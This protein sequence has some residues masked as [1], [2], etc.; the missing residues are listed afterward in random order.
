MYILFPENVPILKNIAKSNS[1]FAGV[2]LKQIKYKRLKSLFSLPTEFSFFILIIIPFFIYFVYMKKP[3]KFFTTLTSVFIFLSLVLSKSFGIIVGL[4]FLLLSLFLFY[5][6]DKKT[7]EKIT[8]SLFFIIFSIGTLISYFRG[9]ELLDLTPLRLRMF[10]WIIAIKEFLLSPFYGVGLGNFGPYSSF[11]IKAGDPQSKY[12]HN[13]FLQLF[14]ETGVI[15]TMIFLVFLIYII[16][17]IINIEKNPFNIAVISSLMVFLSYNLIDIGVS[18]LSFGFLF[19]IL[20]G[21]LLKNSEK[22]IRVGSRG[23]AIIILL[24]ILLIPV[25]YSSY[26][27]N[28]AKYVWIVDN[29]ESVSLSKQASKIFPFNPISK[30]IECSYYIE[31][32]QNNKS[33]K[34]SKELFNLDPISISTYKIKILSELLNKDYYEA[35][36]TLDFA[37]DNYKNNGYFINL[38]KKLLEKKDE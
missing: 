19:A 37:I 25:F 7:K 11:F 18:F 15:G 22:L 2:L 36:A 21:S 28:K 1:D 24:L 14:A 13:F 12:A 17:L 16:R 4:S 20:F 34:C 29:K 33:F 6:M 3:N 35:L 27:S 9:G 10:H 32:K 31:T 26:L 30:S 23:K 8:V 38:K 5:P